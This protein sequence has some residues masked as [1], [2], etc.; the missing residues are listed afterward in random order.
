LRNDVPIRTPTLWSIDHEAV[1][2]NFRQI[3]NKV[4]AKVKV[5]ALKFVPCVDAC[6]T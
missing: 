4:G 2:W 5:L 3:R 1:R 6:W